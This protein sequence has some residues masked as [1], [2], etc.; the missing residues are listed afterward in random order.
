MAKSK[1][2]VLKPMVE[3]PKPVEAP[4]VVGPKKYT[5]KEGV[6]TA[7]LKGILTHG[8]PVTASCWGKDGEEILKGLIDRGHVVEDK[9]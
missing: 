5:M 4:K 1:N 2:K 7:S 3:A 6:S 8:D 9:R